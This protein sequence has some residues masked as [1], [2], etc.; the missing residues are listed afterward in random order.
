MKIRVLSDLHL[1]CRPLRLSPVRCDLVVLAGDVNLGS[2]GLEW[3]KET[4]PKDLP[5]AY[6]TGNHEYY[7]ADFPGLIERLKKEAGDSAIQ[8]LENDTLSQGGY[9]FFGGTLWTDMALL[10]DAEAHSQLAMQMNDYQRIGHSHRY[11]LLAPTDTRLQHEASLRALE[12][13]LESG[14]PRR[15]V[16]ITHHAPSELSIP[17][18][19]R[20]DPL[21][22]A[23]ASRLDGLIL[24]TQPLL[25]IHGH[26]HVTQRYRIGR[27]TVLA[28]PRGYYNQLQKSFDPDLVVDLDALRG[29]DGGR[30]FCQE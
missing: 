30:D 9:R 27:T 20:G 16:V 22:S 15:S 10:G 7:G 29:M 12:H 14:D 4:F 1:E 13:F 5:V 3:A 23:Y 28:N 6:V 26:I 8:V 24:R 19:R 18:A 17:P 21:S 2:R 25:W 11:D